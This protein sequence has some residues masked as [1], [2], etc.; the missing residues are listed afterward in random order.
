MFELSDYGYALPENLIANTPV[1]NRDE[2]RLLVLDRFSGEKK[3]L[4]FHDLKGLLKK[5]DLL[6]LNDTR[7]IPARFF[8]KK[9]SGGKV[10]LLLLDYAGACEHLEHHGTFRCNCLVKASKRPKEGMR[11]FLGDSVEGRVEMLH[12]DGSALISFFSEKN[13]PDGLLDLGEIPLPP[14]IERKE[15]RLSDFTDYQT[16]FAAE[17]GAVAAPTAGL[18]FTEKLLAELKQEGV[19]VAFLTLHVGYGT[20]APVRV[21]DIRAHKMHSERFF[22]SG[23][24]AKAISLAKKEGRRIV[25]TGT[26]SV[27]TLEYLARKKGFEQGGSGFCDIFIYPG[28][29]FKMVDAMI[30]N[31][32]LPETTLMM[33]VSAFAGRENIMAAYGEAVR[34]EYRFFSYGDA[35]LIG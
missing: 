31:F 1:P 28:F 34:L 29:E 32:H 6:V 4:H 30:T 17:K 19:E 10:E 3:H 27:R 11:L 33:L 35:M 20:F 5:G 13:M 16:V 2:A 23:K 12:A 25:A 21:R 24:S 7:V 26:T 15:K 9:E 14:Y 8:G 22:L 18:H